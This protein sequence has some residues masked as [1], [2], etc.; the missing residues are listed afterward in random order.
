[1]T[2]IKDTIEA[3]SGSWKATPIGNIADYIMKITKMIANPAGIPTTLL[4]N[5]ILNAA[6]ITVLGMDAA[7]AFSDVNAEAMGHALAAIINKIVFNRLLMMY[8]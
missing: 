4:W 8:V 3:C 7:T 6:D 5:S 2:F 1:M